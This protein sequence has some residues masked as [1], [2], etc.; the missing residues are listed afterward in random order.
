MRSLLVI[1]V[2]GS[3]LL[4]PIPVQGQEAPAPYLYYYSAVHRGFVIERADGT[5][6]RLLA[7]GAVPPEHNWIEGPGWSP[8]G[9][10][11]AWVSRDVLSTYLDIGGAKGYA[12]RADGSGLRE[13]GPGALELGYRDGV[14]LEWSPTADIL[15]VIEDFRE[16]D[17]RGEPVLA[18]LI[19]VTTGEIL[20]HAA[21]PFRAY[22]PLGPF[23]IGWSP[24]G[25]HAGFAYTFS[26]EEKRLA[27]D[28][29]VTLSV[30]G[31][32]LEQVLGP[33]MGSHVPIWG[34]SPD[35]QAVICSLELLK[36]LEPSG[37][38]RE[39]L[40]GS[41]VSLPTTQYLLPDAFWRRESWLAYQSAD[42]TR[43]VLE[44]VA[45][46]ETFDLPL[47]DNVKEVEI[48]WNPAA[49]YALVQGMR[50]YEKD[51]LWLL[52]FE[53]RTYTLIEDDVKRIEYCPPDQPCFLPYDYQLGPWSPD[54]RW[55]AFRSGERTYYSIFEL[56][57]QEI[58]KVPIETAMETT[59]P[60][61]KLLWS[62]D[63]RRIWFYPIRLIYDVVA[64][65]LYELSDDWADRP[66]FSLDGQ[67]LLFM[68][69]PDPKS[70]LP[71][72]VIFD[73]LTGDKFVLP[74]HSA[75][76]FGWEGSRWSPD[77]QWSITGWSQLLA[78]SDP[79]LLV[80]VV[81]S[82]GTGWREIGTS[83]FSEIEPDWLPEQ[84]E[85]A[86]L[87]PGQPES[88]TLSPAQYQYDNLE[89]WVWNSLPFT[90]AIVCDSED[91]NWRLAAEIGTGDIIARLNYKS[92]CTEEDRLE[93]RGVVNPDGDLLAVARDYGYN[94]DIWEIASGQRL[95]WLDTF[96]PRLYFSED[97]QS[98]RTLSRNAWLT[99]EVAAIRR[100]SEFPN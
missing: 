80:A 85:V 64:H 46:G 8:S 11:F 75:T 55:A 47:P 13:F 58:H 28:R 74:I 81:R 66:L 67:K 48:Y 77:S 26:D 39:R 71:R 60:R 79:W 44:Q 31:H 57:S 42:N 70:G 30:D 32:V 15:F 78:G 52:S 36:I 83:N 49:P 9:E 20:A 1:L 45:S 89:S 76:T 69:E 37:S 24:D 21:V 38:S 100:Q 35:G 98:L 96:A 18:S 56:A 12:I 50:S 90:V 82:D 14:T 95:T 65:D 19:N 93:T 91:P 4:M 22:S 86:S 34:W 61:A 54:G 10:W 17:A 72:M 16:Y 43:L 7:G 88:V 23:S 33:S 6:S 73:M 41:S 29:L 92:P 53:D 5:D 68:G 63:S 2:I 40:R 59:P 87:P 84:V 3:F 27:E 25:Q 99:W 97:G 62:P 94:V 51:Y